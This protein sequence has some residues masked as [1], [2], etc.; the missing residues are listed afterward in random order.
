[1]SAFLTSVFWQAQESPAARW[2][3]AM[4]GGCLEHYLKLKADGELK[5]DPRQEEGV[6][7]ETVG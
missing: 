4:P 6:G 1:M 2:N 5:E 7:L 3:S